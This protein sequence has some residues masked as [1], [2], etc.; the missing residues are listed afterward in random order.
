MHHRFTEPT[1]VSRRGLCSVEVFVADWEIECCA[2]PPAVGSPSTWTL[3]FIDAGTSHLPEFDCDHA[4]LAS[5]WPAQTEQ[6]PLATQLS[7][8]P[9]RAQW[10]GTDQEP[11]TGAAQLRGHLYGTVHSWNT[12]AGF[13]RTTG[14]V[15]R[16]QLVT[17]TFIMIDEQ[18]CEAI[19]SSTTLT[20][21]Q[22]SPRWFS[23][24]GVSRGGN[25]PWTEHVG[26]LLE[27]AVPKT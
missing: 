1:P 26:V 4:W 9:V 27:L 16:I 17:Q 11:P 25:R 22:R 24:P 19:P 13:P 23:D 21:V 7:G 2:P 18:R 14:V 3:L 5:P 20:D 6:Q 8:G 15:D 12:R 10:T